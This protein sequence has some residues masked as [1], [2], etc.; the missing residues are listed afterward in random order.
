MSRRLQSPDR[1]G[2]LLA[3]VATVFLAVSAAWWFYAH[4]VGKRSVEGALTEGA[5]EELA[6]LKVP[7]RK[8]TE[9][10]RTWVAEGFN[11]E[12]LVAPVGP[13]PCAAVAD[14]AASAAA[15]QEDP[16]VRIDE[17]SALHA[18][19][20]DNLLVAQMLGTTLIETGRHAEAERVLAEALE[21]SQEDERIIA[22][23]RAN[24]SVD[25]DDLALSN[26]IHVHH[27]LGVARLSQSA[28]TPP[29]VSLK[30][31]IGSV[32]PL[33]NRRLRRTSRGQPTWALLFIAAPG[34][35][36]VR[37]SGAL[38]TYDL[39]NN[40]VV[41]YMRG[42]FAGTDRDREREFFRPRKN[43]PGA[44]HRLLLAQ[45]ERAKANGWQNEAQLW[46]LSNVERIIDERRPED[47]RL[48]YNSVQVIDWWTNS[49]RCPKE[50]C[51]PELLDGIAEVRNGLV[52]QAF[53]R[54]NVADEQKGAFARGA[55]GMLASSTLDRARVADAS[56]T[57]REWLPVSQRQTLAD[58]VTA[59]NART[60]LPRW[61][62][63][64]KTADAPKTAEER[65][66]EQEPPYA[67]LGP[68]A[69][70]WYEAARTDVAAAVAAW[71]APRSPREQRAALVAIRQLL[72]TSEAPPELVKLEGQRSWFDRLV[73]RMVASKVF[74]AVVAVLIGG[75][76]WL[77]LLWILVHV[78]EW[79]L[80]RVSFYNV[81]HEYLAGIDRE[82]GN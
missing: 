61:L 47:A 21:E 7:A 75:L 42:T 72:G 3:L 48:A 69:Q 58:L 35:P 10:E 53:R 24:A 78:R 32:K 38:S 1:W 12:Y 68:R 71:A 41:G 39:Y 4:Q 33:I 56:S 51:T 66:E 17:L 50:V 25:L 18:A 11:P 2:F 73:V 82:P 59:G 80:L 22:A 67:K 62:F 5:R 16:D 54:R 52:E 14:P 55:V 79:G 40:L 74:W 64:P 29:W 36:R 57:L 37:G 15:A 60:A 19:A 63:A 23:S 27:A 45:V 8:T 70:A 30:N 49:G 65:A 34:C 81:E 20:P 26:V 13:M 44:L 9:V 28:T 76:L 43:Y 6:A 31:V 46:A 77:V